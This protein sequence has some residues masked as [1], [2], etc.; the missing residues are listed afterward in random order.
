MDDLAA[1]VLVLATIVVIINVSLDM[2]YGFIDPRL[3]NT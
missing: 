2:A 3:R 1:G